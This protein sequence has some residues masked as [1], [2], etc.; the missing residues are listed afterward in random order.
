[1][2]ER[3][4]PKTR[5]W[6]LKDFY[7]W[8]NNPDDSCRAFVL[9]GD[10]GIGKSV[11]AAVIAKQAKD[12]KAGGNLAAAFFSRHNDRTRNDPRYLLGT[13]AYQL[14][15][16]NNEYDENVG[17]VEGIHRMLTNS[18]LGVQELFTKLLEEPLS[19]CNFCPR[20]LVVIDALDETDSSSRDEFLDLIMDGFPLLP[21]WLVFFITSRPEDTV[22]YRLK[23]YNPL[24]TICS[25]NDSSANT[26]QQHIADIQ[27]FLENKLDFSNLPC[28]AVEF[29]NQCNG[30]FLYAFLLADRSKTEPCPVDIVPQDIHGFFRKNFKRIHDKLKN[31]DFYQKL[32]GCFV[33]TPS[34]LPRLFIS[35]LLQKESLDESLAEQKV[36]DVVSQFVPL[37]N[38]DDTFAFLHNLIPGWLTDKKLSRELCVEKNK[39]NNHFKN[40][41]VEYLNGFLQ[42]KSEDIFFNE[43]PL[44]NYMLCVGFRFLC[45]FGIEEFSQIIFNCLTNYRFLQQRIKGSKTGIYSL[46]DDLV[47][48]TQRQ[49]FDATKKAVLREIRSALEKDKIIL[50][51]NHQLLHSCLCT[52]TG[53]VCNMVIPENK[54]GPE[55]RSNIVPL[56]MEFLSHIDCGA[57][58][59]DRNLLAAGKNGCLY[60][61][62]GFSFEKILGPVNV[63]HESIS[64]LEFSPDDKFVFFGRLDKWLSVQEKRVV[65]MSQF[66]ENAVSYKWGSFICDGKYIAVNKKVSLLDLQIVKL[67]KWAKYELIHCCPESLIVDF[68]LCKLDFLKMFPTLDSDESAIRA[69]IVRDYAQIFECQIWNV[70]T[71][72]PVLEEMF[73]SQLAP[74]FYIW[75]TCFKAMNYPFILWGESCTL[76]DVAM[77]NIL[78]LALCYDDSRK[79]HSASSEGKFSWEGSFARLVANIG[80]L[81]DFQR[82]SYCFQPDYFVEST[83]RECYSFIFNDSKIFSKDGMWVVIRYPSGRIELKSTEVNDIIHLEQDIREYAFTDDSNA[84]VYNRNSA[85]PNLYANSLATGAKLR[86]TSGSNP[87]YLPSGDRQVLGFIFSNAKERMVVLLRDLPAKFLVNSWR[88]SKSIV[89][90]EAVHVTFTSCDSVSL[91]F[92]NGSVGSGKIVDGSLVSSDRGMPPSELLEFQQVKSLKLEEYMVERFYFSHSGDLIVADEGSRIVLFEGGKCTPIKDTIQGSVACLTFSADDSLILFCVQK[93]DDD[94]YIYIWDVNTS[95]LTGPLCLDRSVGFDMHVESFCFSSDNSKLFLCSA[96]SVSILKHDAKNAGVTTLQKRNINSH[97]FDICS[98]CTVSCDDKWLACCIANKILIYSVDDLDE[99]CQVPHNHQGKIQYCKFLSRRRYLISYGMD[100]L[101]FLFDL[102]AWQSIAYLRLSESCISIAISPDGDKIVCLESPSKISLINLRGLESNLISNLKLPLMASYAPEGAH[103]LVAA[104]QTGPEDLQF[105][106]PGNY[107]ESEGESESED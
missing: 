52:S 11:I 75:H 96:L 21:K 37:R 107:M 12:S 6:L 67:M 51:G 88:G 97:P 43:T 35:F 29:T 2:A 13:I 59:H 60:L 62:D 89:T 44:V 101:M 30:M 25:G 103:I 7:K 64:H 73:I 33:M 90:M 54:S 9:I 84:L 50:V 19:R 17:G 104:H 45:E 38:T 1:M 83:I 100:W 42:G 95:T 28:T 72:R 23:N 4:D 22:Q 27:T 63:M 49:T 15:N 39:A 66:S 8:F 102:D 71:G 18:E 82:M 65:E 32:F 20:Q 53:L 24:I 58:S 40:I 91:L 55:F 68:F 76:S 86:S 92:S 93:I 48:S 46:I 36:I 61:C 78:W 87:V 34:P 105:I 70:Q 94:Q 74:F 79:K 81:R 57:F 3:Y 56:A 47:F 31:K 98:H 85:S 5:Q 99:F 10:A 77:S 41:I 80:F 26:Y 16:R 69:D 14:S 106:I